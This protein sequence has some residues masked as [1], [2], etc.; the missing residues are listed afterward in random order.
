MASI[1]RPQA[2]IKKIPSIE[3][4]GECIH[5]VNVIDFNSYFK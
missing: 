3:I 5:Y 2:N 1:T 4:L